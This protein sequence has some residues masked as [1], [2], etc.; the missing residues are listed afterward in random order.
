MTEYFQESWRGK[1]TINRVWLRLADGGVACTTFLAYTTGLW[2][3]IADKEVPWST[4][5]WLILASEDE[6]C[7]E[8]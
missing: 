7:A 2:H 5:V 4:G 8:F 1:T 6:T 3:F